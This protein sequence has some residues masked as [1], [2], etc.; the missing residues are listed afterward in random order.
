MIRDWRAAWDRGDFPFLFVQLP[1]FRTYRKRAVPSAW[2]ELRDAQRDTLS[3]PNTGMAVTIDIGN[4]FD[5][6]PKNK[7]EVGRRLAMIAKAKAYGVNSPHSG[8]D[9]KD[10]SIEGRQIVLRFDH[11]RGGLKTRNDDPVRGFIIAG[12][13]RK[14]RWAHARLERDTVV[15]WHPKIE[16]PIAVRYAWADNPDCNLINAEGLPAGPFRTD[17]WPGMTTDGR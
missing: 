10:H 1:N 15:V 8:P 5:I 16:K 9:Y 14:W 17:D 4:P 3:E 2:A 13:D 6:H 7:Q 12:E 11:A